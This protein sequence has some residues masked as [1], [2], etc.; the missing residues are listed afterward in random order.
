MYFYLYDSFLQDKKYNNTLTE[1]EARL[2]ELGINGRIGKLNILKNIKELITDAVKRGAETITLV[3]DDKTVSNALNSIVS[4]DM[5]RAGNNRLILGLIPIGP[6]R[7]VLAHQLGIPEGIEACEVLSKRIKEQIDVA[8]INGNYFILYLKSLS[9]YVKIVSYNG[10]YN[11]TPL[12]LNTEV[13]VCNF[14]SPDLRLEVSKHTSFFNPQDGKLELVIN[15]ID[16]S[17][18]LKKLFKKLDNKQNARTKGNYTILPFSN[19]KIEPKDPEK[20]VRLLIDDEKI[21][22]APIEIEVLPKML[23]IIVGKER[24]FVS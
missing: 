23:N 1:I 4:L 16:G 2:I 7:N 11:I 20:D 19:I 6:G 18:F 12:D 3:G 10:E 22:K 17:S 15:T 8:K 9:P 24:L 14:L 13:F 21:I 5:S